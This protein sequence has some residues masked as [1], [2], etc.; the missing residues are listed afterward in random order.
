MKT[1]AHPNYHHSETFV[2]SGTLQE[3]SGRFKLQ[4]TRS[5]TFVKSSKLLEA[6]GRHPRLKLEVTR[7]KW[8]AHCGRLSRLNS[9]CCSWDSPSSLVMETKTCS[10]TCGIQNVNRHTAHTVC[11]IHKKPFNLYN[12]LTVILYPVYIFWGQNSRKFYTSLMTNWCSVDELW[13]GNFP[14][15]RRGAKK[16]KTLKMCK[17][18]FSYRRS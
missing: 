2:K 9:I 4:V 18:I 1:A 7:S 5:K 13:E 8:I 10:A 15:W 6:C 11:R 3:A 12:L 16:K 17:I 14:A